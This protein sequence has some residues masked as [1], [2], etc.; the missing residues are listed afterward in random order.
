M[1]SRVWADGWFEFSGAR[2][3]CSL[4][5]SGVARAGSKRE[6]DGCTPAGLWPLRR[7]FYR[8]D[9][10]GLPETGLPTHAIQCT[11]GW[12]DAPADPRYNQLVNLPH[13]AS[14]E[15]LWRDDGVYDLIVSLG[16][17]D[18]PVVAGAGSASFLHLWRSKS[19]PTEGCIAL[20][21]PDMISFLRDA[22]AGDAILVL[23]AMEPAIGAKDELNPDRAPDLRITPSRP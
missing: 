5:R 16:Y 17:N 9:R 20:A 4:G 14:A 11:D 21:K 3:P 15:K 22:T 1:I 7:V 12:C 6:G 8:P 19:W 2:R 10:V 13:P 23:P 18:D